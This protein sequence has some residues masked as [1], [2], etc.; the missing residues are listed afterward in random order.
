MIRP[1][2]ARDEPPRVLF[3][4]REPDET[5]RAFLPVIEL[6]DERHGIPSRVLF[7]HRPGAWASEGLRSRGVA[8][9]E[10]GLPVGVVPRRL[11]GVKGAPTFDEIARLWQARGLARSILDRER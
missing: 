2:I 7:H 4:A 3:V 10:V 8:A 6:L 9:E 11:A 1:M 5:L